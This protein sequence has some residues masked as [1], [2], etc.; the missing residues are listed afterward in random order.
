VKT[1]ALRQGM[2]SV[3]AIPDA[4]NLGFFARVFLMSC[5][6]LMPNGSISG[7]L[8]GS[9]SNSMPRATHAR[10]DYGA[11]TVATRFCVRTRLWAAQAKVKILSIF[12][13]PTRAQLPHQRDRL[14]PA[15]ACFDPLS[16]ASAELWDRSSKYVPHSATAR[17]ESAPWDCPDRRAVAVACCTDRLGALARTYQNI[18]RRQ[19]P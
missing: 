14:Q 7:V 15:K 4:C 11:G 17:R 12:A 8:V 1:S 13:G 5:S 18:S 6:S 3:K 19:Q 9:A 2:E 10:F 16:F